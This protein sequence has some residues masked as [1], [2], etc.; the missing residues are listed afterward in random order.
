MFPKLGCPYFWPGTLLVVVQYFPSLFRI[1]QGCQVLSLWTGD[2]QG[3]IAIFVHH[4]GW[5][6]AFLGVHI[7]GGQINVGYMYMHSGGRMDAQT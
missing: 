5:V 2:E 7:L 4:L 1:S 3:R 6:I